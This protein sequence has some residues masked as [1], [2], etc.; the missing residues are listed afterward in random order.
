VAT[1]LNALKAVERGPL[2]AMGEF[3]PVQQRLSR[4]EDAA[5]GLKSF[6]EKRR[7]RFTGR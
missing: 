2:E 1:R 4:T 5:E 7:S 6:V 3:I